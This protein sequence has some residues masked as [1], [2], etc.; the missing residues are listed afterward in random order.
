MESA[1]SEPAGSNPAAAKSIGIG[2]YRVEPDLDRICG[3]DGEK[4]LEPKTMAVLM[5]LAERKGRV[6]S[7]RELIDA[8]WNGRPMGDNPVYRC[9]SQLRRAFD[10]DPLKPAFIATVPTKGYCLVA[11]V[12]APEA[13]RPGKFAEQAERNS[14]A[15][16]TSF[17][18]TGLVVTLTAVVVLFWIIYSGWPVQEPPRNNAMSANFEA[19]QQYMIGHELMVR[20][21]AGFHR[22]ALNQFDRAIAID[23]EFAEAYA[24]R[25]IVKVF[26]GTTSPQGAAN[27]ISAEKDVK[28]ALALN[29]DSAQ[30]HAA[31]G[32]LLQRKDPPDYVESESQLR[33][34]VALDPSLV[35]A[36]N[37]L[38][39]ALN[40]QGLEN[41]AYQA[42]RKAA[43]IDPLAPSIGANLANKEARRGMFESAEKRL[44]NL[45]SV[46]QPAPLIYISL[47]DLY[48]ETG[49]LSDAL[50][51]ARNRTL[52][53]VHQHGTVDGLGD[54]ASIFDLLGDWERSG[55]W[56]RAREELA[57]GDAYQ[58]RIGRIYEE[59]VSGYP[60][61]AVSAEAF[62]ETLASL[63][64]EVRALAPER[65]IEYGAILALAGDHEAAIATLEPMLDP[66]KAYQKYETDQQVNARHA[67]VWALKQTGK[68]SHWNVQLI[69][70]D[71]MFRQL[72]SEG[73]LHL[74][75]DLFNY[76]RNE[77]L[78]GN[79]GHALELLERSEQ[80]GW[81]GYY[82]IEHD[83]RWNDVRGEPRFIAVMQ[84][85]RAAIALQRAEISAGR[86]DED[87]IKSLDAAIFSIALKTGQEN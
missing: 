25:A 31:Q 46:P 60:G 49:R 30:A 52:N 48:R 27:L 10:D 85:V 82:Q 23:P 68:T 7:A 14:T 83:P 33:Q 55:Y 36:W 69:S 70:L 15:K 20:R 78:S 13:N 41:E 54:L 24:E 22:A 61:Y 63:G 58:I 75:S 37:W 5:Y 50:E 11:P 66:D 17:R 80:A 87:F 29:P 72:D 21:P 71:R 51:T 65:Q 6:V 62:R 9:I 2:D 3:P 47:I 56:R 64:L 57:A 86:T 26:E 76:A 45:L 19:Y 1:K 35:N 53:F 74:S 4:L 42:Q 32:F 81:R 43:L 16:Y 59:L 18:I 79:T 34:A 73:R 67:L 40:M 12:T 44:T 38:A 39:E 28:T 84:R 77:V 8:I